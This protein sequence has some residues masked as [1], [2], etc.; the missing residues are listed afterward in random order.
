MKNVVN[1]RHYQLPS[2][3]II[4]KSTPGAGPDFFQTAAGALQ[5]MDPSQR[6]EWMSGDVRCEFP[7]ET[8]PFLAADLGKLQVGG[9]VLGG[10]QQVGP[11]FFQHQHQHCENSHLQ[12]FLNPSYFLFLACNNWCTWCQTSSWANNQ[13]RI[14]S[15]VVTALPVAPSAYWAHAN[16]PVNWRVDSGSDSAVNCGI[17]QRCS[18]SQGHGIYT[19]QVL[20]LLR[21]HQS[22]LGYSKYS[23]KPFTRHLEDF[24]VLSG[25]CKLSPTK[26]SFI[27]SGKLSTVKY[28]SKKILIK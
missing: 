19:T 23:L 18:A 7:I 14:F 28:A 8:H 6:I 1:E 26:F 2:W 22:R 3:F 9:C 12:G 11:T 4:Q 25:S 13:S 21:H 20:Q 5:D 17:V 10:V 27:I 24:S 15:H 16:N